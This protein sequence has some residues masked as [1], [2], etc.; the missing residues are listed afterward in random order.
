MPTSNKRLPL[1][2]SALLLAGCASPPATVNIGPLGRDGLLFDVGQR[3]SEL[4]AMTPETQRAW[5]R[6]S[7]TPALPLPVETIA[8]NTEAARR[9][10]DDFN[11]LLMAQTSRA[12][13][14]NDLQARLAALEALS[15]WA[16]S[17]ALS[18]WRG[19]AAAVRLLQEKTLIPLLVSWSLLQGGSGNSER[20]QI[21]AWLQRLVQRSSEQAQQSGLPPLAAAALWASLTDAPQQQALRQAAYQSALA[22]AA[23]AQHGRELSQALAKALLLGE[24][25]QRQQQNLYPTDE[26]DAL[27][28]QVGRLLDLLAPAEGKGEVVDRALLYKY[29][30]GRHDLAWLEIYNRRFT[31]HPNVARILALKNGNLQEDRPLVWE[32]A[33]GNA[34]CYFSKAPLIN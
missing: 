6:V 22:E 21:G 27:H 3:R 17:N 16:S 33:G 12:I 28:K 10:L 8:V 31:D 11:W 14:L 23:A 32:L 9:A 26:G 2:L 34:S 30:R 19:D 7:Q 29:N 13:G 18:D 24:V 15:A 1:L 5:C 20:Q 4:A 25:S